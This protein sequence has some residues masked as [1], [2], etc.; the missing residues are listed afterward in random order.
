[1]QYPIACMAAPM[2]S[3]FQPD[4]ID[5]EKRKKL[6]YHHAEPELL[7]HFYVSNR[8]REEALSNPLIKT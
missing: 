3:V 6:N 2:A 4:E 1:M 7:H 5:G 8:S